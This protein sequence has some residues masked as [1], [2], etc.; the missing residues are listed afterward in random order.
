MIKERKKAYLKC[1]YHKRDTDE[2]MIMRKVPQYK[3]KPENEVKY[4]ERA[5]AVA[6]LLYG[7]EYW[8]SAGRPEMGTSS[9]DAFSESSGRILTA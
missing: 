8:T 5:S 4:A 9:G 2:L 6:A 7:S 3:G 1:L